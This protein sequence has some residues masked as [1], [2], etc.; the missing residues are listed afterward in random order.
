[1]Q[2]IR[3]ILCQLL[4]ELSLE[5]LREAPDDKIRSFLGSMKDVGPKTISCV[6]LFSLDRSDLPVLEYCEKTSLDSTIYFT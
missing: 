1:M 2:R 6:L 3:D 5:W 4:P